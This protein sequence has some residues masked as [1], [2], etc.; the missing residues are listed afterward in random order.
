VEEANGPGYW[1]LEAGVEPEK[2]NGWLAFL[3]PFNLDSESWLNG[4]N[5]AYAPLPVM[6]GLASGDYSAQQTQVYLNGEVYEEGGIALSIG[7]EVKISG[8]TS[9][10]CTPIGETWKLT[11]VDHIII[12][13]IGNR[14][15]Y[16]VWLKP[17]VDFTSSEGTWQTFH[18]H[19]R[20]RALDDY[21]GDFLIRNLCRRTPILERSG[22]MPQGQIA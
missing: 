12:Q 14:R 20:K 9:Q 17:F 13:E 16:D 8:I 19:G 10:G 21:R 6:G 15:A 1:I 5:E 2:T 7:G 22:Y 18:W 3:N 4:W 11:R